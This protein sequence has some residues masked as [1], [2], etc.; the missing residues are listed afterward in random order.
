MSAETSKQRNRKGPPAAR[1]GSGGTQ[2]AGQPDPS[3]PY[4]PAA[5]PDGGFRPWHLFLI[6]SLLAAGAGMV[7][8]RGAP[9]AHVTFVALGIGSAGVAAFWLYRV[10]WPLVAPAAA[11]GPDMLGGRTRAALDREKAAVLRAIKELEFDRAMGKVS[12]ADFQDMSGRLRARAVRLI[13]QLDTGSAGYRELIEREL[14]ARRA[15]AEGRPAA[16]AALEA[17]ASP[18]AVPPAPPEPQ[19]NASLTCGGCGTLNDPD[20]QFC[21][22]CGNRLLVSS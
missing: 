22:Q 3:V 10:V 4:G 21:K 19:A 1:R 15:A 9:P 7:A 11:A 6:G 20:A 5:E 14:A 16:A 8:V 12:E 2:K 13:K 18:R 17:T